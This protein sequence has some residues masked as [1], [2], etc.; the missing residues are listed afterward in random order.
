MSKCNLRRRLS[1]ALAAA[2][3]TVGTHVG[4]SVSHASAYPS[5][6]PPKPTIVLVHGAWA[7]SSSWD[8]VVAR[9]QHDGYPVDV[10][11]TPLRGL[12]T[13][14]G[15]LRDYLAAITGP[16][17]LVG[18]S[19]GGAV[20]TDA[21]TGNGN[22]K[23]LVYIDAFAP[24]QGQRVADLVGPESV[25]ANPNPAQIF[26][27]VPATS[28]NPDL[29]VLPPVFVNSVANDIP[30]YKAQVLA[31]TQRPIAADALREPSS[32]PAWKTIPSWY[33]IGTIDKIIPPSA[34][35]AMATTAHAHVVRVRSSHLPMVSEP[36]AVTR[37]IE[38]A[39]TAR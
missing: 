36:E 15:Y 27:F 37:T 4:G 23:K 30:T 10:F 3:I 35:L 19:Y 7:D 5:P 1:I 13:D 12:S 31:A 34:Q 22:V 38:G 26:S 33:E 6:Q 16:I 21:A 8:G 11:P 20:V 32:A 18:H 29:Y 28:M 24:D 14:S 17:V 25:L 39:A 9:L 2:T